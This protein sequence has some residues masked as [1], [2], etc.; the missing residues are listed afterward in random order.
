M[1]E[2]PFQHRAH[3]GDRLRIAAGELESLVRA[4]LGK[5]SPRALLRRLGRAL[6]TRDPAPEDRT[7][8]E[9]A[10]PGAAASCG[11]GAPVIWLAAL[12]WSWRAQ[13]PQRLAQAVADAGHPA[14]YADAF[15]RARSQPR[16]WLTEPAPG[17][18]VVHLRP[19][20]C[21]DLFVHPLDSAAADEM[22][23]ALTAGLTRPPVAVVAQHP[24]WTELALALKRR[25]PAVPLV[26][27]RIDHHRFLADA[28][29]SIGAA[30]DALV[31]ACD[32][33][34]ATSQA[35][36]DASRALH[37][38]I[39]IVRNGVDP[40]RFPQ[41]ASRSGDEPCAGFVGA[42]DGRVDVAALEAAATALPKWRFRFAGAVEHPAVAALARLPNVELRGE[43]A[44]SKVPGFLAGLDVGL[45]PY[46]DTALTRAIDPVKL[47]EMLACGL[48]VVASRLPEIERWR[49]P[50]VFLYT[51]EEGRDGDGS[52]KDGLAAALRKA[53]DGDGDPAR[54]LRREAAVA[55]SW[56]QRARELLAMI[57]GLA[58]IC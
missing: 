10:A 14:V 44:P 19:P 24:C 18:Q 20:G 40:E 48:P 9:R 58:G 4:A 39:A 15:L 52:G 28:P 53:R 55:A 30:E 21:R 26:Y 27:D 29:P 46:R 3:P 47:Y 25:L 31:A 37:G 11:Q 56:E 51:P 43:I 23:A 36:A 17:V 16:L 35:L 2:A 32:L 54:A 5:P 45:V 34:T 57:E 38:R 7:C 1:N 42:L 6:A 41:T 33:V 13:R 8:E 22:A 12:P 49:E 50:L